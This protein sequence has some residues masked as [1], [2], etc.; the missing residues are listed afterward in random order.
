MKEDTIVKKKIVAVALVVALAAS[1][2]GCSLSDL[3]AKFTGGSSSDY[4][5]EDCITLGEYKGTEVDVTVSDDEVQSELTTLQ[6]EKTK[7]KKVKNRKA[8]KGDSAN[9]DYVG[10]VDGKEFDGGSSEGYS[11]SLGSNTFIDGFEDGVIGMKAGET[12]DLNLKF[13]D[14]YSSESLKGKDVVF[15]VT[16]NY[17]EEEKVP[18]LN[19]EFIAKNTDYKTIDEF[20]AGKKAELV[21][22]KKDNAGP[23]ALNNISDNVKVE[24]YPESLLKKYK[25]ELD[26]QFKQTLT[27]YGMEFKDYLSQSGQTEDDYKKQLDEVAKEQTKTHLIVE[28]IAGKEKLEVK[29]DEV[30][31]QLDTMKTSYKLDSLDKLRKTFKDSYG[32]DVDSYVKQMLLQQ[33]VEEFLG[34]NV[35]FKEN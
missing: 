9:I 8:K 35:K 10:K 28:T 21:Q 33:K 12:K 23:T 24:T 34:K 19:D 2:T 27:S 1:M 18:E 31:K 22:E 7:T 14:D 3:K 26:K 32:M 25:G 5:A 13:P 17:I 11:L 16:L 4:V 6:S 30:S 20:K 15:T 29:E